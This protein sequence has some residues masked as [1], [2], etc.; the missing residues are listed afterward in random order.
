M[1]YESINSNDATKNLADINFE[2]YNLLKDGIPVNY[3]DAKGEIV[4][5]KKIK[6]F[7]LVNPENNNFIAVQ[8][9]WMEENLNVE[10]VPVVG[11]VNG[12]PLVFVELKA[13]V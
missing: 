6:V 10:G 2:K 12:L 9:L 7:D 13:L 3:K 1:A 8:Q 11:F 4:R 5:N